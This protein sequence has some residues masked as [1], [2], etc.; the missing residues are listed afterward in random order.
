MSVSAAKDRS[1]SAF[2]LRWLPGPIITILALLLLSRLVDWQQF[3][4]AITS[5]PVGIIFLT[6][7][8]Y[9]VSLILRSLAWRLLLQRKV[10][11]IQ[12]VI[13]LS[14]GY[15]FNNL[16]PFRIGELARGYLMGR[17]SGLGLFRVLST[18]V[19][20]RSYDLL[21]AAGIFLAA[22]PLA[23]KLKWAEPAAMLLLAVIGAALI[24]LFLIAQKR[25]WVEEKAVNIGMR[26]PGINRWVSPKIHSL[27]DGFSVLT[28]VELFAGS[29]ALLLSSWSLAIIRDWIL[30]RCFV[31]TAPIWWAALGI[32]AANIAGAI[33][34]VM[35]ALGTFELGGTGALTLV[36]MP[37]E[38]ALAYLL[39]VHVIHLSI[40][41]CL[42]AYGL[43]QEG[44][45]LTSL[46]AE[47]RRSR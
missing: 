36:G 38:A 46:Y 6:V 12:T 35:G 41:T 24:A 2:L 10:S 34:S 29:L 4:V 37:G 20:E 11:S 13:T 26:W 9:L 8:F 5:I 22:I 47:I 32:S 7:V 15:F 25:D 33:P 30:I 19:V 42:G 14:E 31:P 23:L 1:P 17:R 28:R 40:S 44:Q 27:L 39:V 16:L 43:S 21:I 18:I 3:I 45:T